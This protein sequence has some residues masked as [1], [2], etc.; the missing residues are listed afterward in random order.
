M[1]IG[2]ETWLND[3]VHNSEIFPP[4]YNIYRRD[5]REGF[6]GVLIAVKADIVSDH[7]D[8]E[9][10]TESVYISITLE[11]GKQL[12]VGALYRPPISS[13]E[14]MD[15]LCTT[16]ETLTTRHNK[17]I[18]WVGRDLNLPDMNWIT[19]AIAGNSNA[20][21]I[22]HRLLDCTQNCG[23]EQMVNF[24]TRQRATLDLFFTNRPSLVDKCLPVPG[25]ADHD[26]VH[27]I[28]SAT[29]RRSKPIS[30][31][32]HLW[33]RADMDALRRGCT[34]LATTFCQTFN[35]TNQIQDMWTFIKTLLLKLQDHHVPSNQSSTRYSQSWIN[36]EKA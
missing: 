2:T 30:R 7:L 26:M 12:I 33:K 21:A 9:I 29:A 35:A 11:K 15:K 23:L 10:N 19:Q 14:Y 5:R 6:G 20:V 8:V 4:N 34:E 25:V 3:S 16:L 32:I 24:P 36:R 17:A 27:S 31:K 28:T 18:F 13:I 22:N 1:I